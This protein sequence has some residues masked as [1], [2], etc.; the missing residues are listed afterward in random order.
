MHGMS[1]IQFANAGQAKAVYNYK[2]TK[3]KLYKTNAAIWFNEICKIEG[4]YSTQI[5]VLTLILLSSE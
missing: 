5:S 1:N 3:E 2:N 4:R